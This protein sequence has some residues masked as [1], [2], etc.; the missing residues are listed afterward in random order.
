MLNKVSTRRAG[1]DP[2]SL[3]YYITDEEKCAWLEL[4]NFALPDGPSDL[5]LA[6]KE[7]RAVQEQNYRAKE[8][9][10]HVITTLQPGERVT[11]E[12]IKQIKDR[13]ASA[14]GLQ[15]HHRITALHT[16]T[17]S[18]HLHIVASRIHPVNHKAAPLSH[19]YR[20]LDFAAREIERDLGLE[21]SPGLFALLRGNNMIRPR[22]L[23][24]RKPSNL[25]D[26]L[27]NT[28]SADLLRQQGLTPTLA[29]PISKTGPVQGFEREE[30]AN[31]ETS[32]KDS[33]G[34]SRFTAQGGKIA[35]ERKPSEDV[36]LAALKT[37]S[38]SFG[39]AL[40]ITGNKAF[41]ATVLKVNREQ[42]LGLN[43]TIKQQE[44]IV[45]KA[46]TALSSAIY[47]RTA[48]QSKTRSGPQ[49]T[50]LTGTSRAQEI[51]RE[52]NGQ[53][54]VNFEKN[55]R[56]SK[57]E[58]GFIVEYQT[59]SKE[60]TP[61]KE[62]RKHYARVLASDE[63]GALAVVQANHKKAK[64]LSIVSPEQVPKEYSAKYHNDDKARANLQKAA[65]N[66][67]QIGQRWQA[68]ALEAKVADLDKGLRS[69]SQPEVIQVKGKESA[70][71]VNLDKPAVVKTPERQR[72]EQIAQQGLA[73]LRDALKGKNDEATKT[74]RANTKAQLAVQQQKT[75]GVN[76][77]SPDGGI[78]RQAI[79]DQ[80]KDK[81]GDRTKIYDPKTQGDYAGKIVYVDKEFVAQQVA[82]KVVV[83][84]RRENM[85]DKT[86][87]FKAESVEKLT[88]NKGKVSN[89][90]PLGKT[91][92]Q[93]T[94]GK[95][96]ELVKS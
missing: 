36:V 3:V 31:G 10:Y 95:E 43:I 67:R 76:D 61:S 28:K 72:A 65:T 20:K 77:R 91:Q 49:A 23:F 51:I 50:R 4:D 90:E 64:S 33:S 42:Q 13:V 47:N 27:D 6:L 14:V 44:S 9:T 60:S 73:G 88:Y 70:P 8:K 26:S 56:Q 19:D 21:S 58:R 62:P 83:L 93:T 30:R 25:I 22:A 16:N 81:L 53:Q 32:Y 11:P 17:K 38:A 87:Q 41:I 52:Q 57:P 55:E 45:D 78:N 39:G 35:V 5:A 79:I 94:K 80:I 63:A 54:W 46:K 71:V 7:M 15:D 1:S 40:T 59:A 29:E 24:E 34:K 96:Q 2:G 74:A 48:A 12:Q 86:W 37:A 85:S 82:N 89:R 84:H 69:L 18:W 75:P 92:P 68:K 66:L